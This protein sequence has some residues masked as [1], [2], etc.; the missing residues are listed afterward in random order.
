MSAPLVL[1]SRSVAYLFEDILMLA[2][3]QV[4]P[5]KLKSTVGATDISHKHHILV[6][7]YKGFQAQLW[8]S[9]Q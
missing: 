1:I 3:G 2:P 6:S 9:L 4:Q 8:T 7:L 5:P